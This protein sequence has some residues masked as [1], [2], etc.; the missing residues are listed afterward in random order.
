M[1]NLSVEASTG[2]TKEESEL[3]HVLMTPAVAGYQNCSIVFPQTSCV[4][5]NTSSLRMKST[6]NFAHKN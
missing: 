3:R 4:V 6:I 2:R 5:V 1:N